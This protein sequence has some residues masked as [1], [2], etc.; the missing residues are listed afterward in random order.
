MLICNFCMKEMYGI[1]VVRSVEYKLCKHHY[2]I[3]SSDL[4]THE[5]DVPTIPV[6]VIRYVRYKMAGD[7]EYQKSL[8]RREKQD[9][10]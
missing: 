5:A 8:T 6:D 3:L 7:Y 10:L 1:I 2:D 4:K 9:G